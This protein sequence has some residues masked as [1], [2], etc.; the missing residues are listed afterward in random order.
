MD[1]INFISNI[2]VCILH[3]YPAILL[4]VVVLLSNHQGTERV[5]T[6]ASGSDGRLAKLYVKHVL[7]DKN[8]CYRRTQLCGHCRKDHA[9]YIP[10]DAATRDR[11]GISEVP[12]AYGPRPKWEERFNELCAYQKKHG[13]CDVSQRDEAYKELGYWVNS[14]RRRLK[15]FNDDLSLADPITREKIIKLREIGFKFTIYNKN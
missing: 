8:L 10:E 15:K 5:A 3:R 11:F 1:V 12:H 14:Q 13:H 6:R 7:V 4:V 9:N 2:S